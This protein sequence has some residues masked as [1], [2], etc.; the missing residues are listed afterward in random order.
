MDKLYLISVALQLIHLCEHKSMDN[1]LGRVTST[2]VKES[3]DK[4]ARKAVFKRRDPSC[5][6]CGNRETFA[7]RSTL[8]TTTLPK[9]SAPKAFRRETSGLGRVT[10]TLVKESGDKEARKA[11]FKRRD[12]SC[13]SCGNRKTFAARSTSATTTLPRTSAPKAFRRETSGLGRVTFTLVKESGDKEA[14]KAV[15]KRRDP[16]CPSCGNKETFA[17]RSRL[18]CAKTCTESQETKKCTS[19]HFKEETCVLEIRRF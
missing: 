18:E 11:V 6:S 13:P 17:A 1:G 19:F 3:G 2:L 16:S 14:R 5:P 8:A 7:A 9:T 4:E 15:F 10:S 12:P